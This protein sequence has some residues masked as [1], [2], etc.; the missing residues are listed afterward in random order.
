[1]SSLL[2]S[3]V[4]LS[5]GWLPFSSLSYIFSC[6]SSWQNFNLCWLWTQLVDILDCVAALKMRKLKLRRSFKSYMT[7]MRDWSKCFADRMSHYFTPVQSWTCCCCLQ[8]ANHT[9]LWAFFKFITSKI[10]NI[11]S[12]VSPHLCPPSSAVLNT[13]EYVSLAH[14]KHIGPNSQRMDRA[15]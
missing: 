8:C 13:F 9:H 12:T 15:C 6:C 3:C 2:C 7:L 11:Q 4:S 10:D 14:I 1:M 5:F